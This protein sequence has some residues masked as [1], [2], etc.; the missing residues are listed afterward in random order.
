MYKFFFGPGSNH[1]GPYQKSGRSHEHEAFH[2]ERTAFPQ[3]WRTGWKPV[4]PKKTQ[5]K[6]EIDH[7]Y[8]RIWL[9]YSFVYF[10]Y[11]V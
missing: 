9:S 7:S 8:F 10:I 2:P 4:A 5:E 11:M 3:S 6:I 1:F